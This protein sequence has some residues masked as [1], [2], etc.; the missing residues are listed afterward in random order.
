M[1]ITVDKRIYSDSVI[2]KA[3]YWLSGDFS[4][5]RR[6][7]DGIAEEIIATSLG[8]VAESEFES[9]LMQALN[10]FK[11]RQIVADETRDIKTI[12]Y[13][14]A[15]AEDEDLSEEDIHD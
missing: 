4:I 6:L 13:A 1:T 3:V 9:R 5:A 14:K 7:I 12:L 10:D 15:F 2:S 11:L 8:D